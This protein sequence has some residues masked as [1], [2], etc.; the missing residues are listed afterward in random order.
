M[1]CATIEYIWICIDPKAFF[2]LSCTLPALCR[3]LYFLQDWH[4]EAIAT[5]GKKIRS[6][7][8]FKDGI[9]SLHTTLTKL[10]RNRCVRL[11]EAE[12][13]IAHTLKHLLWCQQWNCCGG[14]P[15]RQAAA[16]QHYKY[17]ARGT[18][19]FSQ[20]AGECLECQ[21]SRIE[22]K[23]RPTPQPP[24][25]TDTK[26]SRCFETSVY[27]Q[28]SGGG[29]EASVGIRGFG[30]KPIWLFNNS[31]LGNTETL[32]HMWFSK[33]FPSLWKGSYAV[34]FV[35]ISHLH[36]SLCNPSQRKVSCPALS[37][38][39]SRYIVP[40]TTLKCTCLWPGVALPLWMQ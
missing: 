7:A 11:T 36:Q 24:K 23:S 8:C 27:R 9:P 16:P 38:T 28:E 37:W 1:Y 39:Q 35:S 14:C 20:V 30:F 13:K 6:C 33:T 22:A 26:H 2:L 40:F 32:I 17:P 18:H 31:T 29:M 10:S 34:F 25:V 3:C 4:K 5:H 15:D 12:L 21:G 19:T